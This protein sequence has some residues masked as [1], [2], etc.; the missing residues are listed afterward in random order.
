M[1]NKGEN[2][3][4]GPINN[5]T[6]LQL[7]GYQ[8]YIPSVKAENIYGKTYGKTTSVAINKEY[9]KDPGVGKP[10][11][12][13]DRYKTQNKADYSK[14]NFRRIVNSTAEPAD[15]IDAADTL[16]LQDE[17]FQGIQVVPPNIY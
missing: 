8:G 14:E 7:P 10:P 16:N 3:I 17:E 9:P 2:W 4:G 15:M 6:A 11:L 5:A 1:S 12:G 13:V